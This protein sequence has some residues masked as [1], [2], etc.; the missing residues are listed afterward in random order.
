VPVPGVADVG[1][2]VAAGAG[3][4]WPGGA[5]VAGRGRGEVQ[6]HCRR[7]PMSSTRPNWSGPTSAGPWP[8]WLKRDLAQLTALF[9]RGASRSGEGRKRG[10]P[11]SG[12]IS[13]IAA[14]SRATIRCR[15]RSGSWRP[16]GPQ[17]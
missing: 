14:S 1:E 7:M 16:T 6:A 2:P 10:Y 8:T 15:C 4:W 9:G 3:R 5:G 12:A 13:V 17:H 11:R